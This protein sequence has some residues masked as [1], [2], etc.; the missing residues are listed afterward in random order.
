MKRKPNSRRRRDLRPG[1]ERPFMRRREVRILAQA[2]L[3]F[4]L[5]AA[6]SLLTSRSTWF[7]PEELITVYRVHGCK[8]A[9]H[10]ERELEE[11]GFTVS[12]HELESLQYIRERLHTPPSARGCHVGEFLG[13]FLEDHIPA[14]AVSRLK[15]SRPGALGLMMVPGARHVSGE[16]T[17]GSSKKVY[18][19]RSTDQFTSWQQE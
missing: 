12:M 7:P 15:R 6:L 4:A 9:F 1:G 14:N 2:A 19:V 17:P 11:A 18:L 5:V 3:A 10:W 8:C 13:Y 16:T